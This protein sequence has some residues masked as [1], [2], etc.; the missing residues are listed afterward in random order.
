MALKS[1]DL[2]TREHGA[3]LDKQT[4]GLD[5]LFRSL[6]IGPS[7]IEL[8]EAAF[9]ILRVFGKL[10]V[11]AG[12]GPNDAIVKNQLDTG[13]GTLQGQID[14]VITHLAS[15]D[16]S[17]TDMNAKIGTSQSGVDSLYAIVDRLYSSIPLEE[18]IVASAGQ[19]VFNTISLT[20]SN[21]NTD[22]DIL[23]FVN[24]RKVEQASL[25]ADYHKTSETQIVFEYGMVANSTVTIRQNIPWSMVSSFLN[26]VTGI[27]GSVV[28]TNGLYTPD[29]N[30]LAVYRNGIYLSN[31]LLGSASDRYSESHKYAITLGEATLPFACFVIY[32]RF[33]FPFARVVSDSLTGFN[34]L[35]PEY[36]LGNHWLMVYRNGILLNAAGLGDSVLQYSETDITHIDV[37][38]A[39]IAETLWTFEVLPTPPTWRQDLTGV[40]GSV[41]SFASNY[42]RGS[43]RLLV[44]KNGFLM[45]N[46]S[47]ISLGTS[48]DRYLENTVNTVTLEAASVATDV[49]SA[50]YF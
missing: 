19:T 35:T 44:F 25:F 20:F 50:I 40:V 30:Q 8:A 3:P 42:V 15:I 21:D 23:V 31:T 45:M 46:T 13:L 41:I 2:I 16:A 5:V 38:D 43:K 14:T 33:F 47:D 4:S 28:P 11:D 10:R 26:Y 18:S 34:L 24:G 39:S 48:N 12:V 37:L 32:N 29:T 6:G 9:K 1:Y 49:W 7:Q 36:T 17:L 27:S 22:F